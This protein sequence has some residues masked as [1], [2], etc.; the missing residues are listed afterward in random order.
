MWTFLAGLGLDG[1]GLDASGLTP[2]GFCLLWEPGLIWLHAGSDL[3]TGAAYFAIPAALVLALRRRRHTAFGRM[4]WL[5]AAFILAC[6]MTHFLAIVTLW[7]PA[8][9]LEGVAKAVTALLSLGTACLIWP[10]VDAVERSEIRF[11]MMAENATDVIFERDLSLHFTY[12]SPVI[13][14]M[15]GYT[16]SDLMDVPCGALVHPDDRTKVMEAWRS[17]ALGREH[18]EIVY[19]GR[20]S[21]GEW[22]WIDVTLR[23]VRDLRGRPRSIVGIAR[24]ISQRKA[25]E[26][27]L[28]ASEGR[29]RLLA[30]NMSD[31]ISCLDLDLRRTYASPSYFGLLGYR[32]EELIGATPEALAHP[33]DLAALRARFDAVRR[34]EEIDA[35]PYRARHR[36]GHYV[37]V[38][39][40]ARLAADGSAIV[41]ALRDV[42]SRKRA[43]DELLA[44]NARLE[45]LARADGLTGLAN[46]RRF[47]EALGVECRRCA[48]EDRPLSL[49]L[50]DIDHF[51]AFNDSYGHQAGDACLMAVAQVAADWARRPADL[52][53]RYGGEEFA[54]VLSD[55]RV[56]DAARLAE[57]MSRSIRE[58][59]IE[60]AGAPNGV[61]T[62]SFGVATIY[63][64]RRANGPKELVRRADE[65]LYAAKARG[66]NLVV[67][68]PPE[69]PE[70][71][72]IA[73]AH[74]KAPRAERVR[75]E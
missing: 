35:F 44:A 53:A 31:A 68:E 36:A 52:A 65:L 15:L 30:E 66:R 43:E 45:Q 18:D 75:S 7:V 72:E 58:L 41:F 11:R 56:G 8:Y 26:D 13:G 60:H 73:V 3:I 14:D 24:D 42:S 40:S 69:P 63:P 70:P 28:R 54:V 71:P 17:V 25:A 2:H 4:F 9:Y 27:R 57:S 10:I 67:A 48:R 22:A 49:I 33:D 23:L 74:P 34:G 61:V 62:A 50:F 64:A 5:F 16:P 6:G 32:P 12:V 38:E 29:Y 47:D 55:T 1:F 21:D 46:R 19:R 59:R 51:K 37:W 20:R 39:A